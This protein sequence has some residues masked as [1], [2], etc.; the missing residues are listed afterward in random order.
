MSQESTPRG[1]SSGPPPLRFHWTEGQV[2]LLEKFGVDVSQ[3]SRAYFVM[4]RSLNRRHY[5]LGV[6][7]TILAAVASAV[8][9]A[10][11]SDLCTDIDSTFLC[12]IEPWI[13]FTAGAIAAAS[14]VLS[15][16][17][18]FLNF[19]DRSTRALTA[20]RM[21]AS[22]ARA[23]AITCSLEEEYRGPPK[24]VLDALRRQIGQVWKN[25]DADPVKQEGNVDYDLVR[26]LQS[27]SS[28]HDEKRGSSESATVD[29][30]DART[31]NYEMV[32]LVHDS[33][34][35]RNTYLSEMQYEHD[36]LFQ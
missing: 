23:I 33:A 3:L 6:P 18:Q 30:G 28:S 14:A 31:I 15:G 24:L 34:T 35:P 7:A 29:L 5:W 10:T 32:Q 25:S 20:G 1:L 19:S 16:L 17:Q 2:S 11:F 13:R 4:G 22:I 8:M 26:P 12:E 9:F 36:R 21:Y 27:C